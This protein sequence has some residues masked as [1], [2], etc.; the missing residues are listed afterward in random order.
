MS[1]TCQSKSTE[2][3]IES[4]HNVSISMSLFLTISEVA[5]LLPIII[6][7]HMVVLALV[8][9]SI[10]LIHFW[11][12]SIG[13]NSSFY[14]ISISIL[15]HFYL[16]IV[17]PQTLEMHLTLRHGFPKHLI[18]HTNIYFVAAANGNTPISL[19]NKSLFVLRWLLRHLYSTLLVHQLTVRLFTNCSLFNE[20]GINFNP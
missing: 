15:L 17:S 10:H 20:K 6:F 18:I 13:T 11:Q 19:T 5:T 16:L 8:S 7:L 12:C 4:I 9:E 1:H 3:N 2:D 14:C